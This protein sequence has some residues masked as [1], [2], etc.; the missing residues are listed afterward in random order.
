MAESDLIRGNVDTI[1]LKVLYEGDRYGYD[2]IKQINARGDGQWEIKQPTVYACLKRLEKQGFV[3]SYWDS[4]ESDGGRRKYYTL[5]DSGKEVFLRYKSEFERANALFGDLI[6]GTEPYIPAD[7]FDDVEDESYS[8]P[9]RRVTRAKKPKAPANAPSRDET[10]ESAEPVQAA[11]TLENVEP[12]AEQTL[13]EQAEKHD[14]GAVLLDDPTENESAKPESDGAVL[15][16]EP[17]PQYIQQDLF[18]YTDN[19]TVKQEEQVQPQTAETEPEAVQQTALDPRDII[20]RYY[21]AQQNE[22]ESYSAVHAKRVYEPAENKPQAAPP[23]PR[24]PEQNK[25]VLPVTP[26]APPQPV[27]QQSQA[28]E[29]ELFGDESIA[30]REYKTVLNELVDRFEV[31]KPVTRENALPPVPETAATDAASNEDEYEQSDNI[32]AGVRRSALELGNDVTIR[33]HNDSA[34]QYSQKYYYYSNRLMMTHYT[35]MCAA[36]FVLGLTLF[37]TFYV[38][39]GMRL[40]YDYMLYTAAGL[41]PIIMFVAA[42]IVFAGNPDKLKRCNFNFRFSLIIRCVITVQVAVV[43][44]CLNLIW[45]MPVGFSSAYIPS[46][47]L[48]LVYAL[49]IPISEVIFKTLLQSGHYSA[50]DYE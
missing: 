23:A 42:V 43:I 44:Y 11:Q 1:I 24:A 10:S 36:M 21:A 47:I 46:L 29:D 8:V 12:P 49:F 33:E 14:D 5:T 38:G 26:A 19:Y 9:K 37:L 31:T 50:V 28:S 13:A 4:S 35:I 39:L 6:N 20:D 40:R 17:E 32:F 45:G 48:P 25:Q 2:L 34:R 22:N 30:R 16:D 15:L 41:L 3:S 18:S 7:D 27:K